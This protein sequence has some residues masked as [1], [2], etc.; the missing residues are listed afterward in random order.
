MLHIIKTIAGLNDAMQYSNES[1]EFILVEAAIYAANAGHKDFKLI[2]VAPERVF[3]LSADI[4]AR[5]LNEFVDVRFEVVDFSGWVTL[6]ERHS[7]T[8]TWD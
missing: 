1:D 5:G 6:T 2:R 7:Q 8:M 4:D 3:L